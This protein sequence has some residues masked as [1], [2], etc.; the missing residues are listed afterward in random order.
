MK[1]GNRVRYVGSVEKL[2]NLEGTL[3][4]AYRGY[5]GIAFD[6]EI[7]EGHD[8]AG[9]CENGHGFYVPLN[10][11]EKVCK[12]RKGDAL[13]VT[14]PSMYGLKG[15]VEKCYENI[16]ENTVYEL[17]FENGSGDYEETFLVKEEE[18]VPSAFHINEKVEFIPEML[19]EILEE[20][21]INDIMAYGT[22]DVIE[23]IY[24]RDSSFRYYT[25][26]YDNVHQ[27]WIRAASEET[28]IKKFMK[29]VSSV[30]GNKAR[31]Y[32][33]RCH[34]RTQYKRAFSFVLNMLD[35][36]SSE[37][38][39]TKS[40]EE[41]NGT[42]KSG[43]V[44]TCSENKTVENI[45]N[46][47]S[48]YFNEFVF[49]PKSS[50]D[51]FTL[52]KDAYKRIL[53]SEQEDIRDKADGTGS[54]MFAGNLV[55]VFDIFNIVPTINLLIGYFEK[56]QGE[57]E[58]SV[59]LKE[60]KYTEALEKY[61]TYVI[62]Y[63]KRKESLKK[64]YEIAQAVKQLNMS[65][66]DALERNENELNIYIKD[67]QNTLRDYYERLRK[68]QLQIIGLRNG[69]TCGEVNT[70]QSFLDSMGERLVSF[71]CE[72]GCFIIHLMQDWIFYDE[73]LYKTCN[74]RK[75]YSDSYKKWLFD[76]LD[77]IVINKTV[78]LTFEETVKV[79]SSGAIYCLQ[80]NSSDA[81]RNV[82]VGIPNTHHGEYNCWGNNT[83]PI[84]KSF[85]NG[86]YTATLSQI[87][88]AVGGV[89]FADGTVMRSFMTTLYN[90]G[91]TSHNYYNNNLCLYDTKT[92]ER[93]TVYD[94]KKRKESE[95]N[96]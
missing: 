67:Y 27:K 42:L 61:L 15:T 30:G 85:I 69:E 86:R 49:I 52:V 29:K 26:Q 28:E 10:E 56:E 73:D 93:F 40:Y 66:I 13:Y 96:N 91:N 82:K 64:A 48:Q 78:G 92:G 5:A 41:L 68:T 95:E 18:F 19:S 22:Y 8:L 79:E 75:T 60:E 39:Q 1:I 6:E 80:R 87:I 81:R 47:E 71:R 36:Y 12:Y 24:F 84:Q 45:I 14:L 9:L 25:P 33:L 16:D 17:K 34:I 53:S 76:L 72:D 20:T 88:S 54:F 43:Y 89:N 63:D 44:E 55:V 3:L 4:K 83:S 94:Y 37:Q 77:D 7:E 31:S 62:E 32:D 11:I 90:L 23:R 57:T 21:P 50:P 59:L 46:I 51:T 74:F 65:A 70:L 2:A 58:Y 35:A 38:L